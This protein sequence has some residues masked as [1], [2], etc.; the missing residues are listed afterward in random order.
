MFFFVYPFTLQAICRYGTEDQKQIYLPNLA[1]GKN[2]AAFCLT[3]PCSGND[4]AAME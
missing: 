1:S 4:Y 3:E 2:I